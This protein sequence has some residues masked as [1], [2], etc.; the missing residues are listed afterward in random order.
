[1]QWLMHITDE[2]RH[3]GQ[4]YH[5]LR[6]WSAT[7]SQSGPLGQERFNGAYPIR[8]VPGT[9]ITGG[10]GQIDIMALLISG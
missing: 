3:P 1:M 7:I 6:Q 10:K 2:M 4:R 5:A 9:V 8:A